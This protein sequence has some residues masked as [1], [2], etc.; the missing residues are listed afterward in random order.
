MAAA[1]SPI[2]AF[3]RGRFVLPSLSAA[4]APW[5][6]P[7]KCGPIQVQILSFTG[8]NRGRAFA[9][10][11]IKVLCPFP[12]IGGRGGALESGLADLPLRNQLQDGRASYGP[13]PAKLLPGQIK[14]FSYAVPK[15]LLLSNNC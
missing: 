4:G 3:L 7:G 10:N 8:L 9:A 6:Y 12:G 2:P 5:L 1:I 11:R 14:S 13:V 15:F